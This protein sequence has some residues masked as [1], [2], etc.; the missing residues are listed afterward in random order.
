[1]E[2]GDGDGGGGRLGWQLPAVPPARVLPAPHQHRVAGRGGARPCP[3]EVHR[4]RTEGHDKRA[5]RRAGWH[6]RGG[7]ECGGGGL[8]RDGSGL[9]RDGGGLGRGEPGQQEQQRAALH[10]GG[11]AAGRQLSTR[12][13]APGRPAV[14]RTDSNQISREIVRISDPGSEGREG[15]EGR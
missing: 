3:G 15:R 6:G 5:A 9:G 13:P 4:P 11:A 14:A 1:M 7:L 2:A 10:G 12:L 8:G